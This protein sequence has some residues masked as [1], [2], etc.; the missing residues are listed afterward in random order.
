MKSGFI[1]VPREFFK[2]ELWTEKQPFNRR[3]AWLDL[4]QRAQWRDR[5][6]MSERYGKIELKRGEVIVSRR[7]MAKA[8]RRS[9]AWVQR[10]LG[11]IHKAD[12]VSIQRTIQAGTVYR[13]EKYDSYQPASQATDPLTDP[14]TDP[15]TDPST[16]KRRS[17]SPKNTDTS[18][19]VLETGSLDKLSK[20]IA[21]SAF[22]NWGERF[23]AMNYGRLRTTLLACVDAGILPEHLPEAIHAYAD[24]FDGLPEREAQ[25]HR[26]SPERFAEQATNWARLGQQAYQNPDGSFTERGRMASRNID[27]G[28]IFT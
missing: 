17:N 15:L 20:E 16:R 18:V 7:R 28:K 22:Q 4:V 25:Y 3:D 19:S 2:S 13:I 23:G 14:A 1:V 8:W 27:W 9:E 24:M 11:A 10:F 21:D 6:F 26:P 5:T 12:Q